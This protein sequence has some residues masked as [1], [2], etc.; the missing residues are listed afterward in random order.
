L[1]WVLRTPLV[2]LPAPTSLAGAAA[3]TVTTGDTFPPAGAA[4]HASAQRFAAQP[5]KTTLVVTPSVTAA[6]VAVVAAK[7]GAKVTVEGT[8]KAATSAAPRKAPTTASLA[9]GGAC[10][11]AVYVEWGKTLVPLTGRTPA[12]NEAATLA[13]AVRQGGAELFVLRPRLARQAPGP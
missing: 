6:S 7:R 2:P 13:E 8:L 12:A 10:L 5:P 9:R 4:L 11:R 1:P 3:A